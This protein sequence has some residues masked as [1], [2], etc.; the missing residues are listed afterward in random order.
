MN[1][2]DSI[3][4]KTYGTSG[5][6]RHERDERG[7]TMSERK[8]LLFWKLLRLTYAFVRTDPQVVSNAHRQTIGQEVGN[9]EHE[10]RHR[11]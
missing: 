4:E 5:S 3:L 11:R 6:S 9:S 8:R 10:H 1:R 2:S 7:K